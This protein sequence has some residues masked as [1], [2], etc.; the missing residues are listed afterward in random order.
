MDLGSLQGGLK[1]DWVVPGAVGNQ[2]DDG[3]DT[4]KGVSNESQGEVQSAG[5][6]P[7]ALTGLTN[8]R[9]QVYQLQ[10]VS[11]KTDTS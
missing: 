1:A 10:D 8:Y 7:C 9:L 5:R 3:A 11:K 2:M 6:G 4:Q